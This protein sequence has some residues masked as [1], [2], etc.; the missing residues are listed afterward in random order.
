MRGVKER[1]RIQQTLKDMQE[2]PA[3]AQGALSDPYIKG[4]IE[5]LI[6]AGVLKV[7]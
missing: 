1:N 7:K 6:A 2:N 4:A 5:K 3:S